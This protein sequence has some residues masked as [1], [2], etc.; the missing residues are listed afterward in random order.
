MSELD[1][2]LTDIDEKALAL[3]AERKIHVEKAMRSSNPIDLVRG[4]M[5]MEKV[6]EHMQGDQKSYLFDFSNIYSGMGYKNKA[7]DLSY[8]LMRNMARAPYVRAAI[9][10]RLSQMQNFSTVSNDDNTVGWRIKKKKGLSGEND[11][12]TDQDKRIIEDITNFMLNLGVDENRDKYTRDSFDTFL[13]KITKDSLE[14]DQSTFEVV[15]NRRGDITKFLAT[16]G[17][18]YRHASPFIKPDEKRELVRGEY[19][20]YVQLYEEK[21]YTDF[22]SWELSFGIRNQTTD[23][24]N[25][26]YGVSE[27]EDLVQIVTWL[28]NS[29]E[30]NGKFFSQGSAPKGMVKLS[31]NVNQKSIDIF[32]R[33]WTAMTVGVQNAWRTP[34]IEAD[35]MEWIDMQKSN[36]DM[37]FQNWIELLIRILAAV[38]KIDPSEMGFHLKGDSGGLGAGT[39]HKQKTDYSKD[40]GLYP[41]L[42]FHQNRFNRYLVSR[43]NNKY[44][45]I[46]TGV[47]VEDEQQL[48]E[49]D[50]KRVGN[51]LTVNEVR[52]KRGFAPIENGDIVL[53]AVYAQNLAMQQMGDEESNEAVDEETGEDEGNM[54]KKN[55]F[56][57][58]EEKGDD[59]LFMKGLNNWIK[60]GLP[61]TLEV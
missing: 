27:L 40:K 58:N 42:M 39:N 50:V 41:L 16:D 29:N 43:L 6:M 38:Y 26:N 59:N 36:T 13:Q 48:I 20:I 3:E 61:N 51:W 31:G 11:K 4:S 60:E 56:T 55:P 37:Q 45:Y 57:D 28:L 30:Y 25:N 44:E 24:R 32:R 15:E 8:T 9:G 46:F 12:E 19:P 5:E 22:H 52:A 21:V 2:K 54:Y 14:L 33:M 35:K 23:V 17:A 18:T 10:T 49:N 34:I 53:N 7:T 47:S 1:K